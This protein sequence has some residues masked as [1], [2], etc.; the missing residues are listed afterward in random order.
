MAGEFT[1]VNGIAR[2]RLA[3]LE[4]DGAL[5][6]RFDPGIGP[7]LVVCG[8]LAQTRGRLVVVG[9]FARWGEAAC[10]G[11][12]AVDDAGAID[13]SFAC[14]PGART[15][16]GLPA[17]VRAVASDSD[18]RIIVAGEFA[19]FHGISRQSIARLDKDGG[20]DLTFDPGAGVSG[21][22]VSNRIH[23]VAV[24]ADGRVLIGG[25]FTAVNGVS[26]NRIARLHT[27]GRLDE[28]FDS[29]L[30]V[31]DGE[32]SLNSG[33]DATRV[34]LLRHISPESVLL[35]GS[36]NTVD[37]Q[38]R[39]GLARLFTQE[40]DRPDAPVLRGVHLSSAGFGVTVHTWPGYVY[41]L[42]RSEGLS[43]G[44]WTTRDSVPGNGIGV[45]LTDPDP[46]AG[47]GFYRLRVD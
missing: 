14:A 38:R 28:T 44:V 25:T 37:G 10:A 24:Q 7:D 34:T 47:R 8:V 21:G 18:G 13:P 1:A 20:L 4:P 12:A 43:G 16:G 41:H 15:A 45:N 27:D 11:M 36:F 17:A 3:R 6:T 42:E 30:G 2:S 32:I 31:A 9:E 5:D 40:V 33:W 22:Y 23:A 46:P 19:M 35:I 39:G 26:R 29:G